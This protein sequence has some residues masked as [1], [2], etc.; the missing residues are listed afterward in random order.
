MGYLANII[1]DAKRDVTAR[2]D[3]GAPGDTPGQI[4]EPVPAS[5][6]EPSGHAGPPAARS[7]IS[8]AA[9]PAS[10]AASRSGPLPQDPPSPPPGGWAGAAVR[11]VGRDPDEPLVAAGPAPSAVS[12]VGALNAVRVSAETA[13]G[14]PAPVATPKAVLFVETPVGPVGSAPRQTPSAARNS[15]PPPESARGRTIRTS[16][17]R[18]DPAPPYRQDPADTPAALRGIAAAKE[19]VRVAKAFQQAPHVEKK[20][21]S[22]A[23]EP[24]PEGQA[25]RGTAVAQ[26]GS[27][28]AKGF[29]QAPGAGRLSSTSAADSASQAPA[30]QRPAPQG[31]VDRGEAS[32]ATET[33]LRP[34]EPAAWRAD[35]PP[36]VHIGRIDI[37]VQAA[38]TQRPGPAP[39]A[40]SSDA[41][42]RFYLRRL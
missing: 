1:D 3:V 4:L 7:E 40:I 19:R 14:A 26:E 17:G 8:R 37:V 35:V 21:L 32:R 23:G 20:S 24:G 22:V 5:L 27:F 2:G 42:S 38:E 11:R 6:P 28:L 41:A 12:P 30:P 9:A 10:P 16:A 36:R 33:D 13:D 29:E 39:A 31:V 25:P 18:A 15:D 34:R